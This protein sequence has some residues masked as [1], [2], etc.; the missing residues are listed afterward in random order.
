MTRPESMASRED[1]TSSE[2]AIMTVSSKANGS[3]DKASSRGRF[4]RVIV[5]EGHTLGRQEKEDVGGGGKPER[6]TTEAEA[7]QA[8]CVPKKQQQQLSVAPLSTET[9]SPKV[10]EVESS[11]EAS[12]SPAQQSGKDLSLSSSSSDGTC[13]AAR[14][15][16]A[17]ST[18]SSGTTQSIVVALI[19]AVE[20]I[21]KSAASPGF[22]SNPTPPAV[23][24]EEVEAERRLSTLMVPVASEMYSL[25]SS[26]QSSEEYEPSS[27]EYEVSSEASEAPEACAGLPRP[28]PDATCTAV[29][30]ILPVSARTYASFALTRN[31]VP[32]CPARHSWPP[33]TPSAEEVSIVQRLTTAVEVVKKGKEKRQA[34]ND[35]DERGEKGRGDNGEHALLGRVGEDVAD[36]ESMEVVAPLTTSFVGDPSDGGDG[37]GKIGQAVSAAGGP[38]TVEIG[39]AEKTAAG[40]TSPPSQEIQKSIPGRAR[41]GTKKSALA[42]DETSTEAARCGVRDDVSDVRRGVG[43]EGEGSLSAVEVVPHGQEKRDERPSSTT[44]RKSNNIGNTRNRRN[45]SRKCGVAARKPALGVFDMPS[46]DDVDTGEVHMKRPKKPSSKRRRLENDVD[47]NVGLGDAVRNARTETAR[48]CDLDPAVNFQ[49]RDVSGLRSS[50]ERSSVP[51]LAQPTS[52]P[53]GTVKKKAA[54]GAM[55]RESYSTPGGAKTP[56]QGCQARSSTPPE[57]RSGKIRKASRSVGKGLKARKVGGTPSSMDVNNGAVSTNPAATV[58]A[59]AAFVSSAAGAVAPPLIASARAASAIDQ[60]VMV[61]ENTTVETGAAPVH[62]ATTAAST[63]LR[64]RHHRAKGKDTSD[65]TGVGRAID[66]PLPGDAMPIPATELDSRRR[67]NGDPGKHVA[68]AEGR[69]HRA[70][71]CGGGDDQS[72]SAVPPES[73]TV[74]KGKSREIASGASSAPTDVTSK[75]LDNRPSRKTVRAPRKIQG[76]FSGNVFFSFP[77]FLGGMSEFCERACC[78]CLYF[79]LVTPC[80]LGSHFFLLS[81]PFYRS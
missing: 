21:A 75:R 62:L 31:P 29:S 61:A 55:L 1:I 4:D 14:I 52:A 77:A 39:V 78:W 25:P 19:R 70:D 54:T 35:D 42:A 30:D 69:Q 2:D 27:E 76:S 44:S 53:Q 50:E 79:E 80:F 34:K 72:C 16:G 41:K 60:G 64:P 11:D 7:S 37:S 73:S 5:K 81:P 20:Q 56:P 24:F 71:P 47:D 38:G 15:R 49:S 3:V 22:E 43:I 18:S 74:G 6:L 63:E 58:S 13:T 8:V 68:S 28:W 40:V 36:G 66:S 9:N 33:E 17:I 26:A 32:P 48:S 23:F 46:D 12:R 10:A 67:G 51:V 59:P 65:A 57:P 45:R